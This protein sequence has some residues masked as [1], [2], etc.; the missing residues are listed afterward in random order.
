MRSLILHAIFLIWI[1]MIV[2]LSEGA[3]IVGIFVFPS[4]S[5]FATTERLLKRLA[6]KGH[7]IDVVTHFPSEEAPPR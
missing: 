2:S 5:H 3:N 7:Y 4:K 6:E 1:V